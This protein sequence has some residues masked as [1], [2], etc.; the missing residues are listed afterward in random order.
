MALLEADKLELQ[1]LLMKYTHTLDY[2]SIDAMG[3]IW[4]EDCEFRVDNPAFLI[5]GLADLKEIFR[6]TTRDFPHVRHVVT[7]CYVETS[8]D[9]VYLKAYLQIMDVR[10]YKVTMFARYI[11]RCVKTPQGWRIKDRSCIS[12]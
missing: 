10:D 12:G 4:T 9:D 2:G 7:N 6:T 11:D 3:E 8:G 5:Q 1:Q